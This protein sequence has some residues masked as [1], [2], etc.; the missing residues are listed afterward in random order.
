MINRKSTFFLGVFIFLIPFFGFPNV[1]KNAF[2]IIAGMIAIGLSVKFSVPKK[3]P[4]TKSK[5][6][7]VTQVYVENVPQYKEY[8]DDIVIEKVVE[9]KKSRRK[10]SNQINDIIR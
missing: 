7:K 10:T 2:T 3:N 6:E 9:E 4:R 8:K 5:K 1:W